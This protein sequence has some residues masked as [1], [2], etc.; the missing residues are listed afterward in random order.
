[1]ILK[2][3]NRSIVLTVIFL[4]PL[5]PLIVANPFF[6]P[7]ITGKAFYFRLLV[8][9]AF[10]SWAILAFLDARYRPKLN[11]LTVAVTVF[12]LVALVADLLGVN[13]LRSIWSNFE[14]MEGWM[15]I[16][17]LWAFFIVTTSVFGVNDIVIKNSGEQSNVRKISSTGNSDSIKY[18]HRWLNTSL[19]ISAIVAIY[20]FA[21]LF[22]WADIHQ[23][24]TR[25]DASLGNAI[26]MAV[27]ML[28]HSFLAGYFFFLEKQKGYSASKFKLLVYGI[29]SL[30]SAFLLFETGTRGTI[31]GLIGGVML[32]LFLYSVF[33]KSETKKS[34]WISAGIMGAIIFIGVIFWMN[35]DSTFVR[36]N[37]VLNRLASISLK[38]TQTQAR[39]YVWPMALKGW[40]ERPILGWGQENFNYVFNANYNPKMWAHEQWFD[41]AHNIYLDWLINAGLVGILAYLSLYFLAFRGVWKS[42]I[43]FKNKTLLTGLIAG[44][45]VHNIFVFD[46]L[47]SYV[48]F[49]AILGF[50]SSLNESPALRSA[51]GTP[52]KKGDPTQSAFNSPFLKG[53]SRSD[54]G[55]VIGGLKDVGVEVVEYVVLPISIIAFIGVSYFFQ[56]RPILANTR[57]ISA[58]QS[59]GGPTPDITI[60][61]KA[62]APNVYVANQEIRE[63][64]LSCA[65]SIIRSQ[66]AP[67][68]T[69]QVFF[70]LANDNIKNQIEVAPKDAR[71]YVLGGN[72]LNAIGQY[73]EAQPMLEDAYKLSPN[74]QS[75]A[76]ELA[77][78]YLNTGRAED[79]AK[80]LKQAYDGD[81]TNP[82]AKFAY[83]ISLVAN[84]KESEARKIFDNDPS[85]FETEQMAQIYL[86]IGKYDKS[87]AIYKTFVENNPK[88]PNAR[89]RLAQSQYAG[90]QKWQAK[91]TMQDIIK[92]FPE[93]KSQVE[94]LIETMK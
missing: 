85:I 69:K 88:D 82:N 34:R 19:A 38:E 89:L 14:R 54:G 48:F 40:S 8:E 23:G 18:W 90:G 79:A 46:N 75:V 36:D 26:Y 10:A 71:M 44:Y 28:F 64:S 3:I 84:N 55:F 86:S 29:Y 76:F 70:Q 87:I 33:G 13:P 21:Q 73:D 52:F 25:I 41:R 56:L 9:I 60:F 47:A 17:H 39:G 74:K 80:V 77:Q 5:F 94:Q 66:T 81:P 1:M 53:V 16:V 12:A 61:Q 27:Y 35:R 20:G 15:T 37:E 43:S 63:Q 50:I 31:L 49:F 92:D 91:Q 59:C 67:A 30:I 22:G 58:L 6:F 72:F 62:L 7:F 42:N 51:T 2:K 83:A 78:N 57:L 24:S 65:G 32:A 45:M 68:P 11:K 93:Y 4:I